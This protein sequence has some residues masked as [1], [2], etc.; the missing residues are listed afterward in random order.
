MKRILVIPLILAACAQPEPITDYNAPYE[1]KYTPP[2]TPPTETVQWFECED[3]PG[4]Y[5]REGFE[6]TRC[7]DGDKKSEPETKGIPTPEPK[8]IEV[9]CTMWRTGTQYALGG[10]KQCAVLA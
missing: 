8:P 10:K 3:K 6:Q 4:R 2:S 7:K 5:Y 9:K 1:G